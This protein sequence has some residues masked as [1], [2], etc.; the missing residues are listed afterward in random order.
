MFRN[1]LYAVTACLTIMFAATVNCSG[2]DSGDGMT[3]IFSEDFSKADAKAVKSRWK[4]NKNRP[5]I[6]N[7][8]VILNNGEKIVSKTLPIK[9]WFDVSVRLVPLSI[10]GNDATVGIRVLGLD[11]KKDFCILAFS[12]YRGKPSAKMFWRVGGAFHGRNIHWPYK[13]GE[14]NELRLL[15]EDNELTAFMDGK[16]IVSRTVPDLQSLSN[17]AIRAGGG[18][19]EVRGVLVKTSG[20]R[21]K[22]ELAKKSSLKAPTDKEM[23]ASLGKTEFVIRR[24]EVL[25]KM[26][27]YGKPFADG[28]SKADY[29]TLLITEETPPDN[30]NLFN[31]TI[32]QG[33]LRDWL[34]LG[35]FDTKK[36]KGR[37]RAI[38]FQF[39]PNE[40][41]LLGKRDEKLSGKTWKWYRSGTARMQMNLSKLRGDNRAA[42]FLTYLYTEKRMENLKI[43]F[44]SSRSY[45]VYLNGKLVS[46]EGY[47]PQPYFDDFEF[48]PVTLK[49]G[50]NVLVVKTVNTG[51]FWSFTVRFADGV[52]CPVDRDFILSSA[53]DLSEA[54]TSKLLKGKRRSY[55]QHESLWKVGRKVE[56]AKIPSWSV[57][58]SG[59]I[60]ELL[61][62]GRKMVPLQFYR[63]MPTAVDLHNTRVAG[64]DFYQF[65]Y[66][67]FKKR[68]KLD[69]YDLDRQ[70]QLIRHMNPDAKVMLRIRVEP[71][72]WWQRENMDESAKTVNPVSGQIVRYGTSVCSKKWKAWSGPRL[73]K[74]IKHMENKWGD[75]TAGYIV[76]AQS[77]GEW[78]TYH[79]FTGLIDVS[80][81]AR[82]YFRDWVRNKYKTIDAVNKAWRLDGQSRL[83][84]FEEIELPS[85]AERQASDFQMFFNPSKRRKLIDYYR[86]YNLAGAEKIKYFCKIVK[87]ATNGK[88][89]TGAFHGYFIHVVWRPGQWRIEGHQAL[90]ELLECPWIDLFASPLGYP[91]RNAGGFDYAGPPITS[92]ALHG[93]MWFNENDIRTPIIAQQ[94]DQTRNKTFYDNQEVMKRAAAYTITNGL[95]MWWMDLMGDWFRHPLIME[96]VRRIQNIANR[97][98]SLDRKP[99]AQ[100]AV[101]L[102]PEAG[103]YS[104]WNFSM[105]GFYM[106]QLGEIA[107]C[108]TPYHFYL[109][110][111]MVKGKVPPYKMYIFLDSPYV[112]TA[113]RKVIHAQLARGKATAVWFYA[114]GV[115]TESSVGLKNCAKLTGISL[116]CEKKLA[117][118]RGVAVSS[119]PGLI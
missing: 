84:T 61:I 40:A 1:P 113:Q 80:D 11:P 26:G 74:F 98:I 96:P 22:K 64:V 21:S 54:G 57:A 65:C 8:R 46:K 111:D 59:G 70:M 4:I 107:R 105:R 89:L 117:E 73:R 27:V 97:A 35:P 24:E 41:E 13:T 88:K 68:G 56:S 9:R 20:V 45:R 94:E 76:V 47:N 52:N 2:A 43:W 112:S 67:P 37:T 99:V 100:I 44:A 93:K 78:Q 28:Y 92:I 25:D 32:P 55:E 31:N 29:K 108:G 30:I 109:M 58:A 6:R 106:A 71:P 39:V 23:L 66:H 18:S 63:W 110:S 119:G 75:I 79:G 83:Q 14:L 85:L 12:I 116:S 50:R 77:S 51:G 90:A 38:D 60:S 7:G 15:Y 115:A 62:D 53:P 33:Y 49:K 82:K 10:N 104:S 19:M 69:F 3:Q 118:L 103:F 42:Y 36:I 101:I 86:S 81:P 72:G 16:R 17:I 48:T 5:I 34:V 91:D 95:A 102:D 114:P 87:D